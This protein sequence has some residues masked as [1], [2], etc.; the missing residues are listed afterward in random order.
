MFYKKIKYVFLPIN[1]LAHAPMPLRFWDNAFQIASFLIH[2]LPS[3]VINHTT[4]I[5]KLFGS[6]PDCTF[7]KTFGCACCSNLR[8]YNARK[9]QFRSLQCIFIGYS[10]L[11]KGYRC[12]HRSTRCILISRDVIFDENVYPFSQAN[13]SISH[14]FHQ[15][16]VL[17]P[18]PLMSSALRPTTLLPD[19]HVV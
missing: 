12:L 1:R 4:P 10:N 13:S 16:V 9:L 2:Q 6:K 17:L 7:L 11:H 15:N 18:V 8:P 5:H 19:D 3:R 14:K